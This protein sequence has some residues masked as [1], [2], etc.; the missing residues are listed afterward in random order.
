MQVRLVKHS[1]SFA[2]YCKNCSVTDTVVE[3][4]TTSLYSFNFQKTNR[5]EPIFR[6]QHNTAQLWD[7][8][9][10]N[11]NRGKGKS[12]GFRLLT[13]FDVENSTMYLD[14]IKDKDDLNKSHGNKEY[15]SRVNLLKKYLKDNYK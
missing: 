15:Q 10:G 1:A 8:R 6:T 5:S 7:F 11:P 12:G 3:D 13:Y 4:F 14:Y 2:S 9:L